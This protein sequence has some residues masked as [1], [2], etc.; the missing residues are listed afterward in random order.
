ML[1]TLSWSTACPDNNILATAGTNNTI[2][3]IDLLTEVAYLHYNLFSK[4]NNVRLFISSIL[5]HPH[6]RKLF[7]KCLSIIF[8]NGFQNINFIL[9]FH[10]FPGALNDGRLYVFEFEIE[11]RRIVNL[12]QQCVIQLECEIFGL[13]YCAK[14]DCLLIATNVGLM[15]WNNSQKY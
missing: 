9:R 2:V 15:G 3:F 5:F 4:K 8:H 12:E 6:Q 14:N 11:N 10:L 1:Y 7:C 13:A